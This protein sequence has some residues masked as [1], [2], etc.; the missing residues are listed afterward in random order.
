MNSTLF[1]TLGGLF[2]VLLI[3]LIYF[4]KSRINTYDNKV[5]SKLLI[6]TIIS[7]ISELSL[8]PFMNIPIL[9]NFSMKLYLISLIVWITFL[10][11][12]LIS[13]INAKKI[14]RYR[15]IVIPI[16]AI[17]CLLII[18]SSI[19]YFYENGVIVYS[20]GQGVNIAY[21]VCG[22]FMFLMVVLMAYNYRILKEKQ[23]RP[24]IIF[25]IF[26]I[27]S[28]IV[29]RINSKLLL[30][31]FVLSFVVSLM[32]FTIENPDTKMLNEI[33]KIKDI[34]EK[35]NDEKSNFLFLVNNEISTTLDEIYDKV[36]SIS[37]MSN[38]QRIKNKIIDIKNL[39]SNS[40]NKMK[41]TI[42]VSEMD[43][44]K[45]KT[46]DNKYSI[47][48]LMQ[49]V[50][51][52]YKS[53]VKENVDFRLNLSSTL[54]KELYGDSIK[55]KQIVNTLLDNSIKYTTTGFIELRVNCIVKYD[56][57]RLIIVVEDSGSGMNLIEQNNILSD[58]SDLTDEEIENKD[59]SNLNLK[60]VRKIVNIIGGLL[61]I[62]SKEKKGTSIQI[63][64]DQKI[65]DAEKT[66]E[67][68]TIEKYSNIQR[69]QI[70]IAVISSDNS[71]FKAIK[72]LASKKDYLVE[73]F[74][75]CKNCLD[76]I[77]DDVKYNAVFIDENMEKIDSK[78]FYDKV[79]ET[80]YNGKIFVLSSTKDFRAKKDLINYGFDSIVNIPID[81]AELNSKL[82]SL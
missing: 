45:L 44:K 2:Y 31:N 36:D 5:Y 75:V 42:D 50:Y 70:K 65:V 76:N 9:L 6:L 25:I 46:I 26:L 74:D 63:I 35:T 33:T 1:L 81:K 49:Q 54:P 18:V 68:Q 48:T 53:K 58:H 22:I 30:T 27:V 11:F 67:G 16:I 24:I 59:E 38:D 66:I 17:T 43:S 32:Y 69:K 80:S 55:L 13:I 7:I 57:C 34:T 28:V 14:K 40:R 79:K 29:Q 23:T 51:L 52:N 41:N 62:D 72:S 10:F 60:T 15:K 56:V 82:D 37:S 39:I 3:S 77:R 12:Y 78:S 71:N 20:Y 61:T 4:S 19:E 47:N 73:Y 64:L 21:A 8:V